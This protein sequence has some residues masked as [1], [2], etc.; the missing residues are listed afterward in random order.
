MGKMIKALKNL[1][2]ALNGVEPDGKYVTDV[3]NN[4]AA[5]YVGVARL[6]VEDVTAM[7]TAQLNALKCGDVVVKNED[8][9]KHTYL[10][11]YKEDE[12]GI[13][14]TY[15]DCEN[16]ETVAYDYTDGEWVFNSKDVTHIG[17]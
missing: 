16:V 10:V 5:G 13:C 6:E 9:N 4:I 3:I 2:K 11:S 14:L 8:G 7:T 17:E 12:Q 15:T 1:G